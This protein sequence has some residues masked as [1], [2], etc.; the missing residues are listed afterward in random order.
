MTEEKKILITGEDGLCRP[1]WAANEPLMQHYY[2]TEWG[3]P[4][5]DEQGMFER[6]CLEG[7]QSGLSWRTVLVK[8]EAFREH[9]E[10]FDPD[11]VAQFD[12]DDVEIIKADP[13]VIRS[14]PKIQA[15]IKNA[16]ATLELRERAGQIRDELAE[17]VSVDE[18]SE[19]D[20]RLLGFELPNGMYVDDGLAALMWSYRPKVTPTPSSFTEIPTQSE[21]SVTLAKALKK[22]GFSFVGPTTVYAMME[23]CGIVDTHLVGSHRR[24]ISGL[25]NEDGTAK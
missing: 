8:R 13:R 22:R 11:A 3:V 7:F 15:A 2:D 18:L 14:G 5:T 1:I 6:V 10:G 19:E 24:G 9:F 25:W 21:E 4:I 23:A 16:R 12:A 20:T 17:G